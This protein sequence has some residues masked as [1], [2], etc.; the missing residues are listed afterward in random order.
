VPPKPPLDGRGQS[1]RGGD[2]D[3]GRPFGPRA[4]L[5]SRAAEVNPAKTLATLSAR[6]TLRRQHAA[7]DAQVDGLA[8]TL[9]DCVEGGTSRG[10]LHPL[11]PDR[12][13]AFWWARLATL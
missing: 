10:F 9:I 2:G 1:A 5:P 3:S 4:E 8:G 12:A 7:D 13:V 6:W 11:L